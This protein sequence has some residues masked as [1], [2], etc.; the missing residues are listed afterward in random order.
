MGKSQGQ[1]EGI[2]Q[3]INIQNLGYTT[4]KVE[5]PWYRDAKNLIAIAGVLA[6]VVG[7]LVTNGIF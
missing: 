7:I 6:T 2:A 5:K 4:N 3:T 1:K